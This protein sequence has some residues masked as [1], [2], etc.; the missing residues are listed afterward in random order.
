MT[1]PDKNFLSI[2][3]VENKHIIN[4]FIS[5]KVDGLSGEDFDDILKF[6]AAIRCS[7]KDSTI[8]G[9]GVNNENAI[10]MNRGCEE[11]TVDNCVIVSGRQNAITI[12]GGCSD[13]TIKDCV[14]E[15]GDGHCDI[16]LGNYSDQSSL[17]VTGVRIIN[18]I[19][20]DGQPL[21][22]R[23]INADTPDIAG[24]NVRVTRP[25]WGHWPIWS[26]YCWLRRKEI[27]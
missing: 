1:K 10:D 21:R 8:S 12:K 6:S 16:D 11:I 26:I 27:L 15:P 13:I 18:V 25:F 2:A 7:I 19:R 4:C 5:P 20:S 14:I 23:V 24:L 22:V 3:D 17:P 9:E